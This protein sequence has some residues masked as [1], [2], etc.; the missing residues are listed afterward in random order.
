[1]QIT[2]LT[3]Y[4]PPDNIGGGEISAYYLALALK[5]RGH[6]VTIVKRGQEDREMGYQGLRIIE[7]KDLFNKEV[8]MWE[9]RWAERQALCFR[10]VSLPAGEIIHAQDFQATLILAALK[11]KYP[12]LKTICTVRDYWP[13]CGF[14]KVKLD[15]SVCPGCLT[16]SD[17]RTCPKVM[18]GNLWQ[19][20]IRAW[21]YRHNIPQRQEALALI[22]KVVYISHALKEEILKSRNLVRAKEGYVIWNPVPLDWR[23]GR[24]TKQHEH[25]VLLFS[26]LL[27]LHKGFAVLLD[28]FAL[29]RKQVACKLLVAGTGQLLESYRKKAKQLGVAS[30]LQFF[31]Q[32]PYA[33]MPNLYTQ[34]QIVVAPSLWPEPFG[35]TLLEGM[36]LKKA[37]IA[38]NHGAH[39]EII[40]DHQTGLLVPP[41]DAP[42]LTKAIITLLRKELLRSRLGQAAYQD[43]M[44]NFHPEKIAK[45]YE[46]VYREILQTE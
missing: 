10:E 2:F 21:R 7:R 37:V 35:R 18:R 5:Q 36:I 28:A 38:T 16:W 8:P 30:D 24:S 41:G 32:V 34:A 42:A 40:R 46:I 23:E 13:V 4:F 17:F 12:Q 25:N 39:R 19:K 29:V 33:E 22:D 44:Q 31:G 15:G 45:Q 43:V 20:F 6:V 3:K 11:R 1:M 26:G 14:G 27:D 9:K